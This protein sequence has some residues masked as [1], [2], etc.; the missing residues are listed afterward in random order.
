M[1]VREAEIARL[2]AEVEYW[3]K[4]CAALETKNEKILDSILMTRGQVPPFAEYGPME[5]VPP[6]PNDQ[7]WLDRLTREAEEELSRAARAAEDG[8]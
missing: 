5:P 2:E 1:W 8:N 7:E 3:R 6:K 4:K